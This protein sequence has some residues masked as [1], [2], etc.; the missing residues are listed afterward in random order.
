MP[1]DQLEIDYAYRHK[2]DYVRQRN[3]APFAAAAGGTG[4]PA[5]STKRAA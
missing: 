3:A 1:I 4:I 5:R 2:V